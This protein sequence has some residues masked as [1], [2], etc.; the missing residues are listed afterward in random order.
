MVTH[1]RTAIFREISTL[2]AHSVSVNTVYTVFIA[3]IESIG[4]LERVRQ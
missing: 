1:F 3:C 2:R 4:P